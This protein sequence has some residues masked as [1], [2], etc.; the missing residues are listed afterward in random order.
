MHHRQ[1]LEQQRE[2][3]KEAELAG[4]VMSFDLIQKHPTKMLKLIRVQRAVRLFL[5]A[6]A[7]VQANRKKAEL[8]LEF[9][10][11]LAKQSELVRV[12][13]LFHKHVKKIQKVREGATCGA[14]HPC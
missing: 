10:Q 8:V 3:E 14:T 11:S 6:D 7:R 12:V 1:H 13:A 9:L 4:T 2:S 5:N